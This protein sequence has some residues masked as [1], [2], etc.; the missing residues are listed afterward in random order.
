MYVGLSGVASG[1]GSLPDGFI[2]KMIKFSTARTS[3]VPPLEGGRYAVCRNPYSAAIQ[4]RQG[5]RQ[6]AH[7]IFIKQD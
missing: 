5:L 4:G 3:S 6:S 7:F 1:C 2:F